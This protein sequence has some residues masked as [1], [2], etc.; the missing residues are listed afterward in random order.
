MDTVVL[1]F[2][3]YANQALELPDEEYAPAFELD[4]MLDAMPIFDSANGLTISQRGRLE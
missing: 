4:E 3:D 1:A 2:E